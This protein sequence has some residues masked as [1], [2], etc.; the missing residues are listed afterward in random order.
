MEPIVDERAPVFGHDLL[1][2]LQKMGGKA[3]TEALRN[4][5]AAALRRA[6]TPALPPIFWRS[7]S[8][9]WPKTGARSSTRGSIQ[10]GPYPRRAPQ[11][12]ELPQ[13]PP[14]HAVAASKP[15]PEGRDVWAAN[16]DRRRSTFFE[17]HEAQTGRRAASPAST[18]SSVFFPQSEQ[19]YSKRGMGSLRRDVRGRTFDRGLQAASSRRFH[20]RS[21]CDDP[22][23]GDDRRSGKRGACVRFHES[24]GPPAP[25]REERVRA[26]GGALPAR[27]RRGRARRLPGETR[28]VRPDEHARRDGRPGGVGETGRESDAWPLHRLPA[29]RRGR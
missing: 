14:P 17:P 9:S 4:A 20:A 16:V 1:L 28:R 23:C 10:F 21:G 27:P 3:G 7:R 29:G 2:L 8:R 11:T 13:G 6:S 19:R 12:S 25:R 18:R 15:P 5:S 26:R 24:E 22:P